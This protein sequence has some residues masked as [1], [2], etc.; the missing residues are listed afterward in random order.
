M[1]KTG[2]TPENLLLIVDDSSVTRRAVDYVTRMLGCHRGV[3]V[4]LLH[5]LPPLPAELLEFGG[6]EDPR[7]EQQLQAEL[8][9]EQQD[10]IASVKA[11]ARQVLDDAVATL[12]DAGLF[13][14]EIEL[15]SSDPLDD[16]DPTIALLHHARQ[17]HCHTIVVGNHSPGWFRNLT[18]TPLIEHLLRQAAEFTLWVVH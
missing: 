15:A 17:K 3:H 13:T 6:A 14:Y 18:G 8:Q 9:R 12:R 7:Q 5:L 10:W 1:P 16:R 2:I 11:P 4:Y